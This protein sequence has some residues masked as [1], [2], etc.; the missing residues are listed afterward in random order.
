[1]LPAFLLRA[2]TALPLMASLAAAAAAQPPAPALL[3]AP[4]SNPATVPPPHGPAAFFVAPD[5]SDDGD[6]TPDRPFATLHRARAAMEGS[7]TR[8]TYVRDGTYAV[9]STLVLG[10]A[11][12]GVSFVAA[13]GAAPSLTGRAAGVS[14]LVAIKGA[15]G[16]TLQGLGFEDTAGDGPALSLTGASGN[17]IAANRFRDN[18]AGVLLTA[19]GGNLILGNTITRSAQ[20]AVEAKDGSDGNVFDSNRID[21]TGA[22]A[23]QGGGFFLHG[24]NDNLITHNLVQNTAGIGIGI[25]NWDDTTINAGNVV[26]WNIV[27]NTSTRSQDSGAI[28]LLGRS[29]VD[30][31]AVIADNL[32]DG[33]GAGGDAHTI[34]IYLDDSVSGTLVQRNI[35]RNIGTHAVQ[36]HGGDDNVIRNNIFDLGTTA[37]SAVL[38]Q[39]APA[40]TNP[41]NTMRGNTVRSNIIT[42]QGGNQT[43]YTFLEGGRPSIASNLYAGLVPG[44]SAD[45]PDADASP[46][47]GDPR[48][49]DAP[50]GD[51][52][53][54]PGSAARRIGFSA[55]DQAPLGPRAFAGMPGAR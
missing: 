27:R 54:Q 22:V 48:F 50:A 33:T 24:A 31:R 47:F 20:S 43:A 10:G 21:G 44:P 12:S 46:V 19:S 14:T 5:G 34:G 55:L 25:A 51:Y 4:A 53:L 1:M 37:T 41:T 42:G 29:H 39:A 8:Q 38:F 15:S 7:A 28:Y 30:T 17:V 11:D 18:G 6:G 2:G 3:A 40:D 32:V 35:V 23:E 36:V 16:V 13:P 49:T 45:G 52:T 9:S 26:T